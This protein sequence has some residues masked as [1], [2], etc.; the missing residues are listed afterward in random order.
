MKI[1]TYNHFFGCD[2]KSIKSVCRLNLSHIGG[3]YS[4][5]HKLSD[6]NKTIQTIEEIS[7]D[8]IGLSE[9]LG[10]SQRQKLMELLQK[11]GYMNFHFGLGRPIKDGG[12]LEVLLATKVKSEFVFS[13]NFDLPAKKGYGGGIVGVFL[14][15]S[16]VYIIQAHMPLLYAGKFAQFKMQMGF[17]VTAVNDLIREAKVKK[18]IVMGDFNCTYRSLIRFF[19]DIQKFDRLSPKVP[20]CIRTNVLKYL[21]RQNIDH[22]FGLGFELKQS[23]F[24]EGMSDHRL[25]FVEVG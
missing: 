11:N 14:P 18:I 19:P 22:I 12:N 6:V 7:P 16:G 3:N 24:I 23:G 17:L 15:A 4:K 25:I 5:V 13:S 21:Y 2:G 9:V 8:V 20:T 10:E 1:A